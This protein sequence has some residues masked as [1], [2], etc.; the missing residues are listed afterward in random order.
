MIEPYFYSEVYKQAE[1]KLFE[2]WDNYEALLVTNGREWL[3]DEEKRI[4]EGTYMYT[5][6]DQ[7][8]TDYLSGKDRSHT[9][10]SITSGEHY[11]G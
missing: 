5:H 8:R 6:I 4:I 9:N 3:N 7:K 10:L 1:L 2:L 11:Y